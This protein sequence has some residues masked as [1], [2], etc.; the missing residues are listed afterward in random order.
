M[1]NSLRRLNESGALSPRIAKLGI[2][3]ASSRR[4][5]GRRINAPPGPQT[6][7][8]Q[9]GHQL[10]LCGSRQ[11]AAGNGDPS[12]R[13]DGSTA[14]RCWWWRIHEQYGIATARV[15]DCVSGNMAGPA[16]APQDKS[17]DSKQAPRSAVISSGCD[18]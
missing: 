8:R 9:I 13:Q 2:I 3:A 11:V 18:R 17:V 6:D 5:T 4:H 7:V 1:E 15:G 10:A 14:T 12:V 16:A